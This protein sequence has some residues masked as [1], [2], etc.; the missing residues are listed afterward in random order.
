MTPRYTTVGDF[1]M[2]MPD[3]STAYFSADWDAG[4]IDPNNPTAGNGYN[5]RM[6]R[7]HIVTREVDKA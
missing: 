6:T 2:V 7:E 4:G 5:K 3:G 1:E